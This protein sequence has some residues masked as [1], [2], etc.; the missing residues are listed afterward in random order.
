MKAHILTRIS[1]GLIALLFAIE[2]FA[3]AATNTDAPTGKPEATIDL[4]PSEGV[5]K[6]K[7]EWRYSD[8]KIVEVDFR[9]PGQDGQPTGAP[10]KTYDY[11][12]HAGGVDFEDAGW[13]VIDPATLK[14]RRA[15]GRLCFN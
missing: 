3:A 8:T 5:K 10:V 4:A 7:G 15:T 14:E 2:G 12:P 6:V 11:T 1:A 13:K 9:A